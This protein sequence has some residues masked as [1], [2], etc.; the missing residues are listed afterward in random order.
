MTHFHACCGAFKAVLSALS[1]AVA[2]C[3]L[4]LAL[5]S[6]NTATAQC[7]P[8]DPTPP[9]VLLSDLRAGQYNV[10]MQGVLDFAQSPLRSRFVAAGGGA[11]GAAAVDAY[12]KAR[13]VPVVIGLGGQLHLV[14]NHHRTTGVYTLSVELGSQGFPNYVYYRVIADL[15]NLTGPAFWAAMIQ[16][17]PV[18]D[19]ECNPVGALQHQYVWLYDRGVLQDP[20]VTPPPMIPDL[21]DDMLRSI[22]ASARSANGYRDFEDD[23]TESPDYVWFFQE[24]YWANYLRSRV[25][26]QGAGWEN[27]G[28]NP[29]AAFVYPA[30]S[31]PELIAKAALLSRD[32]SA[33][34][35]PGFACDADVNADA[36]VDALDLSMVIGAWESQAA[37]RYGSPT[38]DC[39]RDGAVDGMDLAIVFQAWG[40]C[41]P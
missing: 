27:L 5:A 39:N 23:E 13:P 4:V 28:G 29:Q 18:R 30:G 10:G 35:L 1:S 37:E 2:I 40:A 36:I 8:P 34:T 9:K 31:L 20:N 16:G 14:D 32:P 24:F 41:K 7:P 11:A 12:L 22:S 21:R 38:T 26:M 3:S 33:A 15:S 6:G 19:E 25:F 17:G